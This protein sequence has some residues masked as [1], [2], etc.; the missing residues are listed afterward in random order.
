VFAQELL[1]GPAR[2]QLQRFLELVHAKQEESET[3]REAPDV[4]FAVQ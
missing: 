1:E 4:K 2:E 3:G